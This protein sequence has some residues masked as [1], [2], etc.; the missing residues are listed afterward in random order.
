[1]CFFV[2][3]NVCFIIIIIIIIIV[4]ITII[5]III[6]IICIYLF[7]TLAL[8]TCHFLVFKFLSLSTTS[9]GQ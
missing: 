3:K 1:M 8:P 6:I 5:I 9:N 2:T 7:R 4:I